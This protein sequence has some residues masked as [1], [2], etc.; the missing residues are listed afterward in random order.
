MN[1]A[2]QGIVT[3]Q[4]GKRGS[5]PCVRDAPDRGRRAPTAGSA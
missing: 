3:I 4:P 2:D 1:V 5:R